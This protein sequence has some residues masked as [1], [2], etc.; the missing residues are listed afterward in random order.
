MSGVRLRGWRR[1]ANAMWSAPNDPQVF[2]ALEIDATAMLSFLERCRARGYRITPAHLVARAVGLMLRD[3]PDFN[4]RIVGDHA[5]PR[6][7]ADVFFITAVD[8]GRDLTGVK[9]DRID[10][11]SVVEVASELSERAGAAKEGRDADLAKSKRLMDALPL[12][13]LRAALKAV[14]LVTGDMDR[15]IESIGLAK[16]PFG[17]AIISNVGTF[18]LPTGFAPLSWTYGVSLLV[19]VGAITDKPVAIDGEVKVRPILPIT[20]T[21]DHRFV[22][23][24]HIGRGM[25]TF[26]GYLESPATFERIAGI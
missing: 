1:I 14:A 4:V 20:A 13:A 9:V 5:Y 16:S 7:S 21:I 26:R 24:W 8:G 17:S 3:V 22:D 19:M 18:G 12:P 15:S 23:G 6:T 10:E 11:K 25:K 2:G